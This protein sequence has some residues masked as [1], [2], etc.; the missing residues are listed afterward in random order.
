M[1]MRRIVCAAAVAL[2]LAA[3][4]CAS[5]AVAP[6]VTPQPG[7]PPLP[8]AATVLP[9]PTQRPSPPTD[10]DATGSLRP[11]VQ[12]AVSGRL[13]QIRDRGRVIVGLDQGSNLFSFRDPLSGDLLG[14]DVDI[15]HQVARDLFGDP[16]KVE[17][18]FLSSA[19]REEALREGTVDMVVKTMTIT[20][21]RA[22]SVA[23]STVYYRAAQRVLVPRDSPV[24]G[25][26]DLGGKT[27]CMAAG[28]TSIPS[29]WNVQP[30]ARIMT[31]PSWGDCLVA[32]QQRQVDAVSTDDT[33]LAGMV[34]QDPNLMIV[35]DPI[36]QEPYGIGM[37]KGDDALVR[38]VNGTLER[39]RDDGTWQHIYDRWLTVLG[40]APEPPAP[41][42]VD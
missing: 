18:H 25:P 24:R 15:A 5:P 3:G 17:F 38:F 27:V 1:S 42:Y 23:F 28:T 22:R 37:H 7:G 32:L 29:L 41:R 12:G 31:V 39:I 30:S 21:E 34:A 36:E 13:Q 2:A 40:P 19:Q 9:Q 16:T 33:I 26:A 8:A 20:C 10:C 11:G 6:S 4:A 14:F 35:G